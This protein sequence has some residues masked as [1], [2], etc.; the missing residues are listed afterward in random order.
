MQLYPDWEYL[1]YEEQEKIAFSLAGLGNRFS[2]GL[3][4]MAAKFRP[5]APSAA[6]TAV[7]EVASAGRAGSAGVGAGGARF[8]GPPTAAPTMAPSPVKGF[9]G[10]QEHLHVH[11]QAVRLPTYVRN[12]TPAPAPAPKPPVTAPAPS[13][14]AASQARTAIRVNSP[15][16]LAKLEAQ[17]Y[18]YLDPKSQMAYPEEAYAQYRAAVNKNISSGTSASAAGAPT[19]RNRPAVR[20]STPVS[21]ASAAPA[22]SPAAAPAASEAAV[23]AAPAAASPA[24]TPVTAGSGAT[25][26]APTA[27]SPAAT[28]PAAGPVAAAE[29]AAPAA[30]PA[31]ESLGRRALGMAGRGARNLAIGGGLALGGTALGAGYA[32]NALAGSGGHGSPIAAPQYVGPIGPYSN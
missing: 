3:R 28:P 5:R 19:M 32:L 26:A 27:A 8:A 30:G 13:P 6:G 11:G 21:A 4:N 7:K 20:A 12:R 31:G 18:R 29:G 24:A 2:T 1:S 23:A 14:Q 16:E 22:A 25:P 10:T 9:R 15:E 17:G